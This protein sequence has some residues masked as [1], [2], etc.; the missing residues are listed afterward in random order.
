MRR[1]SNCWFFRPDPDFDEVRAKGDMGNGECRRRSPV[2][3]RARDLDDAD[4]ARTEWCWPVVC[5]EDWCGEF[6]PKP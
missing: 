2:I 1:C 4:A 3:I 5:D 6:E